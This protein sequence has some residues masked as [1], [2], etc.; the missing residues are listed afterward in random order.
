M[1]QQLGMNV[2]IEKCQD[3]T[4]LKR[5]AL[6]LLRQSRF[7]EIYLRLCVCRFRPR[8]LLQGSVLGHKANNPLQ[9]FLISQNDDGQY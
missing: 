6:L 3:G 8:A 1:S 7:R 2:Q 4:Y 5:R 9:M